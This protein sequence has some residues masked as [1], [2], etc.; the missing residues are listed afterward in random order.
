MRRLSS[1]LV[2]LIISSPVWAAQPTDHELEAMARKFRIATYQTY[3]TNRIEYDRRIAACTEAVRRFYLARDKEGRDQIH[4]WFVQVQSIRNQVIPEVPQIELAQF[5]PASRGFG[6]PKQTADSGQRQD[7]FQI[8]R[9]D[10]NP[11]FQSRRNSQLNDSSLVSG[12]RNP[13]TGV[14]KLFSKIGKSLLNRE[15]NISAVETTAAGAAPDSQNRNHTATTSSP[16]EVI[17]TAP[18][19]YENLDDPFAAASEDAEPVA[20]AQAPDDPAEQQAIEPPSA[21]DAANPQATAAEA[22]AAVDFQD[23]SN[24]GA[25]A[26]VTARALNKK[27]LNFNLTVEMLAEDL[28]SSEDDNVEELVQLVEHLEA[29]DATYREI[30]AAL[31]QLAPEQQEQLTDLASLEHVAAEV[32]TTVNEWIARLE[33]DPQAEGAGEDLQTTLD[34]LR[35]RTTQVLG[36]HAT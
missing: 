32:L 34:D 9:Y 12:D 22:D 2:A 33:A 5:E 27:I 28:A 6:H 36:Q 7:D 26:D 11:R 25:A 17:R 15:S 16:T 8:T 23:E 21:T 13:G 10:E 35:T 31:N 20:T 4:N 30:S 18:D 14:V 24:G 1:F 3:R 29:A 19:A